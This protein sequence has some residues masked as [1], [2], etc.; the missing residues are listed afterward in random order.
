MKHGGDTRRPRYSLRIPELDKQAIPTVELEGPFA[1]QSAPSSE[2]AA[3][4]G[5][6][7]L[8]QG[9]LWFG[10]IIGN[11]ESETATQMGKMVLIK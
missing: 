1:G 8:F 4:S 11:M 7:Y 9:A 10:A 6:N 2:F 3:G 5:V